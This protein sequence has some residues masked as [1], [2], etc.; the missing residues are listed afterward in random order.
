MLLLGI[1][2]INCTETSCWDPNIVSG[3]LFACLCYVIFFP[4]A[5]SSFKAV[6]PYKGEHSVSNE[7]PLQLWIPQRPTP[8]GY[9]PNVHRSFQYTWAEGRRGAVDLLHID[10]AITG[11]REKKKKSGHCH[12]WSL[13]SVNSLYKSHKRKDS[14]NDVAKKEEKQKQA[15]WNILL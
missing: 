7:L 14:Q 6:N 4:L 12:S 2:K 15:R 1:V 3:T 9:T 8:C 11:A 13:S 10:S 5:P